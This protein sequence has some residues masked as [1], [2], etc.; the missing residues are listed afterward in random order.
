M[1]LNMLAA[2]LPPSSSTVVLLPQL[3]PVAASLSSLSAREEGSLSLPQ[4]S[5]SPVLSPCCHGSTFVF[6]AVF[7]ANELTNVAAG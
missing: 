3:L 6:F 5:Y 1:M 2:A 4:S 7:V